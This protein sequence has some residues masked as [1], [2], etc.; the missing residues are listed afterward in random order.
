MLQW[1]WRAPI[2]SNW[3]PQ[4]SQHEQVVLRLRFRCQHH[5]DHLHRALMSSGMDGLIFRKKPI[6]RCP[7]DQSSC[8][9]MPYRFLAPCYLIGL[10]LLGRALPLRQ[11]RSI[12]SDRTPTAVYDIPSHGGLG[13]RFVKLHRCWQW[14]Q[15]RG[16]A[17]DQLVNAA[18]SLAAVST[19]KSGRY[20]ICRSSK[21]SPMPAGPSGTQT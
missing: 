5:V 1:S 17:A 21:A 8:R 7:A 14:K 11:Q 2:R 19:A 13:R 3:I 12:R 18:A 10:S 20:P 9:T 4:D 6:P 15:R 16:S